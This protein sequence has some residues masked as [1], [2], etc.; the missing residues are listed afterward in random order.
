MRKFI[1]P[2]A[3]AASL[4]LPALA[5]TPSTPAVEV[6]HPWARAT[7]GGA[8]TGAVYMTLVNKGKADDRLVGVSSPVAAKAQLHVETND[9]GV[10]K[11]RPVA[12]VDLKPG[13]TAVLKPG[14]MHVMLMGLKQPL[15]AGESFPLTL[16]FAKGGV[17]KV[18]VPVEKIGAMGAPPA[19]GSMDHMHMNH[20]SMPGGGNH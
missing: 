5:E 1:L 7:P 19:M 2:L 16:E 20:M 17:A 11:M 8:H 14:G 3:L 13:A 4:A 6:V 12:D 9:N 15:K 10:M 18:N